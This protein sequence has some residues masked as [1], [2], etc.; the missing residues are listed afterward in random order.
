M[1]Y[2]TVIPASKA[3][4]GWMVAARTGSSI[5]H[6]RLEAPGVDIEA[7]RA[8]AQRHYPDRLIVCPTLGEPI[9]NPNT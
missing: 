8:E 5:V 1:P 7:A 2:A 6:F 3:R 4:R 9:P